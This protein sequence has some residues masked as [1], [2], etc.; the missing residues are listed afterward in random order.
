MDWVTRVLSHLEQHKSQKVGMKLDFKDPPA[1]KPS[2]DFLA[3]LFDSGKLRI[4]LWIN[5]DIL[6]AS[7][8][9]SPFNPDDFIET[10]HSKLPGCVLSLGWTTA[11]DTPYTMPQIQEMLGY[12]SKYQLKH[13]T[14]PMRSSLC[15]ASA[16]GLHALLAADSTY[17]LTV[18]DGVEKMTRADLDWLKQTFDPSRL[19]LDVGEPLP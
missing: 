7:S 9:A 11:Q 10:V 12:C 6:A 16:E 2:L 1:V 18:W 3:S 5:A 15:R 8:R 17:T 13:V 14:F 19:F 4:P